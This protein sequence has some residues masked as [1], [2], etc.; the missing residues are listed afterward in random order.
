MGSNPVTSTTSKSWQRKALATI[1][2]N[3]IDASLLAGDTVFGYKGHTLC[4]RL[5]QWY[6]ECNEPIPSFLVLLYGRDACIQ[7]EGKRRRM[8]RLAYREQWYE[9]RSEPIPTIFIVPRSMCLIFFIF[10]YTQDFCGVQIEHYAQIG[11][12]IQCGH[13]PS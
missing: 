11:E 6:G 7:A 12:R 2:K 13:C 3:G 5:A 10:V 1:D 8:T 4:G 9:E